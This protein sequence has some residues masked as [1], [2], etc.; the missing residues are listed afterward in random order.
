MRPGK[1]RTA[2]MINSMADRLYDKNKPL[3]IFSREREILCI[4]LDM[5]TKY[6]WRAGFTENRHDYDADPVGGMG[7]GDSPA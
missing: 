7:A 6:S 2:E 4:K 5:L 3:G 1:E